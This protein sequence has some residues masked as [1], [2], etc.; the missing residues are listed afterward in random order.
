M[1]SQKELVLLLAKEEGAIDLHCF[2]CVD[3]WALDVVEDINA[4]IADAKKKSGAD[5]VRPGTLSS[6]ALFGRRRSLQPLLQG[7]EFL[8]YLTD[9]L[10]FL[11]C[12]VCH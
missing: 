2:S 1:S 3:S 5:N 10:A 4:A 7:T 9:F 8:R 12:V 6:P 11:R